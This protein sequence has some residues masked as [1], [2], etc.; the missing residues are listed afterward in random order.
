MIPSAV[1]MLFLVPSPNSRKG[2]G[3]DSVRRECCSEPWHPG[4]APRKAP[5]KPP[6]CRW[7]IGQCV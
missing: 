4:P 7:E 3:I 5:L 6:L 2:L 1:M